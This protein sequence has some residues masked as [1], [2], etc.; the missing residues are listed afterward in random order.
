MSTAPKR[1]ISAEEYLEIERKAEFKSEYYDGDIFAMAGA[2][3]PHPRIVSN[4]VRE[5]GNL[6]IDSPCYVASNDV[7]VHV[8]ENRFYTYPD[9][10]VLCSEEVWND[11]EE[12]TTSN[13]TAIF[14]VL[15]ESTKDYDRG[16]K[17]ELYRGLSSL[18]E[19]VLVSQDK[20]H[21]EHFSKQAN[22]TWLL[23]ERN[24]IDDKLFL[25][26]LNVEFPLHHIYFRIRFRK[27]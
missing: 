16:M 3:N 1:Y 22:G 4:I 2:K 8:A 15:S 24:N 13:P 9:A 6:L 10:V 11:K 23:T 7:R 25:R 21:V 27:K 18:Q 20:C 14:E 17:F 26:S 19:Y 5:L 12:D